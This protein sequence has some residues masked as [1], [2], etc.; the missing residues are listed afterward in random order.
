MSVQSALFEE[1]NSAF[2]YRQHTSE[3]L[4]DSESIRSE[5][6][7]VLYSN[8]MTASSAPVIYKML[9]LTSEVSD[10]L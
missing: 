3:K 10:I 2:H 5:N 6:I 1:L 4:M 8:I 9:M 7:A